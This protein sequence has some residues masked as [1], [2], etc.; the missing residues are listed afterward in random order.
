MRVISCRQMRAIDRRAT[1]QF[2]I[3]A[4]LL[5]ENAGIA[6]ARTVE[7]FPKIRKTPI[8]IVCGRG[9]N[10]GDGFVAA[11]H[12]HNRGYRVKVFLVGTTK[13]MSEET[14]INVTMIE[15]MKIKITRVSLRRQIPWFAQQLRRSRL[16][17]DALFGIGIRGALDDFYCQ[18][19]EQ[20]NKSAATVV[21]IDVPSGLDADTG[22]VT[23]ISVCAHTTVT[24]G[25]AKKGFLKPGAKKFVGR[26]V[27]ADISLPRQLMKKL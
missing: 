13:K 4:L 23:S 12:L 22:S 19:I 9:N 15:K 21:S 16:I 27:I 6:V 1:E 18:L 11:R 5:M 20:I 3:P 7:K 14:R 26:L 17:I 24:M 8:V 2:G 25:Y 10:G